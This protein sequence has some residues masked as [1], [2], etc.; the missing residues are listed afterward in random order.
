MFKN[1]LKEKNIKQIQGH[2]QQEV[3]TRGEGSSEE[4][5]E[6]QIYGDGGQTMLQTGQAKLPREEKGQGEN[7]KAKLQVRSG[8]PSL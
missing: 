6:S 8:F 5:K 3:V 4:S 7:P 2:K 1:H